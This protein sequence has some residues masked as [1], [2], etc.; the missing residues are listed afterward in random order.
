MPLNCFCLWNCR[1]LK[2]RTVPSKV[3]YIQD[4]VREQNQLFIALTETWLREHTDAELTISGYTLFRQDRKRQRGNKGRDSR[5]VAVYMRNDIAADMVTVASYSNGVIE[6]IG[7]F[8]KTKNLLL[9]VVYRQPDDIS[10]GHRST[11]IEFKQALGKLEETLTA[12][13]SPMPDILLCGDFNLPHAVW[14][15]GRAGLGAKRDEKI[16]IEDLLA[17][18]NEYF[19]SQL[20]Q[21]PTH[22]NG[23]TLDLL[24]SN[25]PMILH[26]YNVMKT[27]LRPRHH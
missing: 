17:L 15:E 5:G 19:L 21:K 23:N 4:L 27:L 20:I 2:P 25:N 18:T 12:T 1:G 26:S 11:Q 3:P 8:S 16:M 13:D 10:G 24:F 6:M 14:T 22:R 9:L 7:L